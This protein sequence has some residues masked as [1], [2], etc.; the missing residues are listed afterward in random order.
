MTDKEAI[1]KYLE[2]H[3]MMVLCTSSL[4]GKPEGAVLEY[5][6]DGDD[7]II[8]TYKAYRKYPNMIDNPQ[9]SA[10]ITDGNITLQLDGTCMLE[11]GES[12]AKAMKTMLRD[13][14]DYAPYYD[15]PETVFFRIKPTWIRLGDHGQHPVVERL[16]ST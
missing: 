4:H 5:S 9:V 1:Y 3:N 2:S 8:N 16:H 12:R 14:P 15:N 11:D 7:L 10:V 13:Y 6:L